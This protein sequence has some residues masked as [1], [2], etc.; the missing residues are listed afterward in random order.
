MAGLQY[1]IYLVLP[2]VLDLVFSSESKFLDKDQISWFQFGASYSPVIIL[3]GLV[4][5]LF[6]LLLG[7]FV[8]PQKSSF[9]VLDVFVATC[10]TMLWQVCSHVQVNC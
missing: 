6:H 2:S 5:H 4:G 3:L 1:F 10:W 8:R 9:Q 7:Q